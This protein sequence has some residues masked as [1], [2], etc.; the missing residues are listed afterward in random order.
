MARS[1]KNKK[2][3]SNHRIGRSTGESKEVKSKRQ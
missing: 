2:G 1:Q 3:K